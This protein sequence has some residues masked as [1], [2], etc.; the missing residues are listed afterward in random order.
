M[1]RCAGGAGGDGSGAAG[2]GKEI[3]VGVW[4]ISGDFAGSR[5]EQALVTRREMFSTG[6][7]FIK[8]LR[9]PMLSFDSKSALT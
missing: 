5:R 6:G 9:Q 2:G 8:R 4:G 7:Y 3:G 1:K